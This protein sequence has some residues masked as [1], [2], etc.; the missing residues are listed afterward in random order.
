MGGLVYKVNGWGGGEPEQ[1]I[2]MLQERVYRWEQVSQKIH[3][4][5]LNAEKSFH[6]EC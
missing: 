5:R 4:T 3:S 1:G 2:D 6:S